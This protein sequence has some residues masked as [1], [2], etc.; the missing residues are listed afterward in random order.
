MNKKIINPFKQTPTNWAAVAENRFSTKQAQKETTSPLS[1]E[2]TQ[3]PQT[4]K[5]TNNNNSTKTKARIA[6]SFKIYP[7]TLSRN[8]DKRINKLQVHFDDLDFPKDYVDSGKYLMFLMAFA[9]KYKLYELYREVDKN[10]EITISQEELDK[11]KQSL[12]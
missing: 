12:K 11:F 4:T 2:Q 3:T 6:K 9:E 10:F 8:F 1:Q 7:G 5:T